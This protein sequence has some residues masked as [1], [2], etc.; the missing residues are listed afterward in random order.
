MLYF[1]TVILLLALLVVSQFILKSK[2]GRV[3]VA[4][5]GQE[6]RVRFSGYDV[7][8]FKIFIFCFAAV[9][10]GIGGAMFTLNVGF[11][12]PTFVGIVPSIEMVIFCAVGGRFSIF[13]AI[14]G[15]LAVNWAKT[16]FSEAYPEL[17]LFA[18]GAMFIGVV[19]VLPEGLAGLYKSQIE[20]RIN[21]LL[22]RQDTPTQAIDPAE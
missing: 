17:W 20:P 22:G 18:M 2:F 11:I 5:R 19:L 13:G 4:M 14:Y 21:K 16:I 1:V 7:A 12:H 9:L 8:D 10:A 6:D 15:A 3:L